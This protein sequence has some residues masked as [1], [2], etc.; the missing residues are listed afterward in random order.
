MSEPGTGKK[1][2]CFHLQGSKSD[3]RDSR[4]IKQ[5]LC[6]LSHP[7]IFCRKQLQGIQGLSS[8]AV[9]FDG[10]YDVSMQI[11]N[12]TRLSGDAVIHLRKGRMWPLCDLQLSLTVEVSETI[13]RVNNMT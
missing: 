6:R 5:A 10:H 2:I 1:G 11:S 12:V 13:L 4:L 3:D 8:S 7:A 9:K